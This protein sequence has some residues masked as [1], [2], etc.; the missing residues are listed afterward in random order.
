MVRSYNSSAGTKETVRRS[1]PIQILYSVNQT[2]D[3][4]QFCCLKTRLTRQNES[5]FR[6][7]HRK[8]DRNQRHD[9]DLYFIDKF[10]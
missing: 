4:V 3:T 1:V 5:R 2:Q 8:E 7:S 9:S 6:P 10:K